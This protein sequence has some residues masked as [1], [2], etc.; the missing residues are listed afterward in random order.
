MTH[1]FP[2]IAFVLLLSS[3]RALFAAPEPPLQTGEQLQ[4][5]VSWAVVPGAGEIT[6]SAAST[7][8]DRLKIITHTATRGFARLLL[9]FDAIAES[10]YDTTTGR[11]LMLHER[12]QNRGK[13]QEH[14]VNFDHEARQARY[15][16]VGA[17]TARVLPMPEGSPTDLITALL[18]T[19]HWN[20]KP[21]DTHDAL[22]L[23]NDDFYELTIHA[24]RYEDVSTSLGTFRSLVLEPRM[25]KTPPKG[26]FK[27]GSTV[28]V[29]IAQDERRRPV[30][31]EIEF[32]IGT[33]TATLEKYVPPAAVETDA[34][35][36]PAPA[37]AIS[38]SDAKDPRS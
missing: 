28:Q 18:E 33:G 21:G 32:N 17:T 20:L 13:Y 7:A 37:P 14:I 31:F 34:A 6:V 36:S 22:V 30:K 15:A 23:F 16:V 9:R 11:L 10:T 35:A 26:M 24:V 19:R 8:P 4:Y 3:T 1:R 12:T 27:R 2:A 25:E 5:R 29:W 38:P